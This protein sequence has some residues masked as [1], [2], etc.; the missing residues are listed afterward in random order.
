M[1]IKKGSG[2]IILGLAMIVGAFGLMFWNMYDENRAQASTEAIMGQLKEQVPKNHREEPTVP[3]VTEIRY[4]EATEISEPTVQIPE[5]VEI[6]DYQ[7]DPQ[8]EMAVKIVNG[9][10][11]IGVLAVPTLGLELPV[12]QEWSYPNLRVAPCRYVGSVYS[13]DLV[14]AAHNYISHF[15]NLK[16]LQPGETITFTDMEG[17]IFHYEVAVLET[18]EPTAVE[19]MTSGNWDLSLF[20]CTVGG[21]L[22]VTVRCEMVGEEPNL[23]DPA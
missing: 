7:L 15:G 4:P 2:L 22:R 10:P 20:T 6:P 5:E 11:Y 16:R 14:I 8:R 21:K 1:R 12:I 3:E 17:N 23:G 18:L 19:E 9:K 13:D